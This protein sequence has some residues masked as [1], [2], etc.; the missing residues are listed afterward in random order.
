MYSPV[1]GRFT[2]KDSWLGDYNRPL[3]LNYWNYVEGNPV[4]YVDPTGYIK[5][6]EAKDAWDAMMALKQ[7]RVN[8]VVDWGYTDNGVLR[9]LL[10][11]SPDLAKL[12]GW[13]C[14]TWE[15]GRWSLNELYI[16]E[17]AVQNLD[18]AMK[19]RMS[20][21]IGPVSIS[22]VPSACGRGC[23]NGRHIDLLDQGYLP[24]QSPH[25]NLT[26]YYVAS[27]VNGTPYTNF[28]Q[29]TVVHELSHA[30]DA[31]N[32]GLLSAKLVVE[33]G[34]WFGPAL[35]CD[36]DKRLPGC[37][38]WF[39]HYGDTPPKGSDYGFDPRED[40]AESVTAYIFPVEAQVQVEQYS[41]PNNKYYK[42]LY[43]SDYTK[44][45]RWAFVNNLI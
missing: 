16:V 44:T 40:F 25:G 27:N 2:S 9:A 8:I 23:T 33:T 34:G 18:A 14:L 30:W 15:E 22:K 17:G 21:L 13:G 4:N 29:W 35:G 1:T 12:Y 36:A 43:Y 19:H 5:E 20:N 11:V 41:N 37:N 31:V 28:D 7:Y 45:K 24:T 6:N 39:Y 38:H 32:H 3:S 42:Y 26:K 10:P